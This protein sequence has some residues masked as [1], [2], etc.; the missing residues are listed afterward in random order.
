LLLCFYL[1]KVEILAKRNISENQP[2]VGK[3][4]TGIKVT[5]KVTLIAKDYLLTYAV[6]LQ[7]RRLI[8]SR[9]QSP[10]VALLIFKQ[11]LNISKKPRGRL[12]RYFF[13]PIYF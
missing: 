3:R 10:P 11:S 2:L 13:P 8:N 7:R 9:G 12:L 5:C 1:N 6:A 4:P